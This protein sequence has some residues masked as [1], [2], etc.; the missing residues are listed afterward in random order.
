[1]EAF[2]GAL[3]GT[4]VNHGDFFVVD[5]I[6]ENFLKIGGGDLLDL[7]HLGGESGR[8]TTDASLKRKF[9]KKL[10]KYDS[11]LGGHLVSQ[12]EW[13]AELVGKFY[14]KRVLGGGDLVITR[15]KLWQRLFGE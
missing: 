7:V 8:V 15:L 13:V 2:W 14:K 6:E 1:M 3:G 9:K 11:Y 10:D 4:V 12:V 5:P